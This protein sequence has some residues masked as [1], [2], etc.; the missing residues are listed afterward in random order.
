MKSKLKYILI[1]IAV[2]VVILVWN[3]AIYNIGYT[4]GKSDQIE[5]I[6]RIINKEIET[7]EKELVNIDKKIKETEEELSILEKKR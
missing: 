4:R 6:Q 1:T 2:I 3:K 7:L 5:V